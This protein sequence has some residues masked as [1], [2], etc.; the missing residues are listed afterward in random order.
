MGCVWEVPSRGAA[1]NATISV[2]GTIA[3]IIGQVG[4]FV[5]AV[6]YLHL[7]GG[8]WIKVVQIGGLVALLGMGVAAT[9]RVVGLSQ[10]FGTPSVKLVDEGEKDWNF[11]QLLSV[12]LLVLPLISAIEILRGKLLL[13]SVI[14]PF[15]LT[16]F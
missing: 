14:P 2:V 11:G 6:W 4:I 1:S 5:V 10:A 3:V 9:V 13:S 15:C 8:K 7:N 16:F 12:L